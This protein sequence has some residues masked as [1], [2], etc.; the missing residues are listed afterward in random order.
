MHLNPMIDKLSQGKVAFGGSTSDLS[1]ENAHAIA[2]ADIDYIYVDMEHPPL[3]LE[4]LHTFLI[5]MIDKEAAVKK[6][7]PAPQVAPLARFPPYGREQA[8][9]IV[10]P[11]LDI[12]LMGVIFNGTET[13]EHTLN[14]VQNMRYPQRKGS[15][16]M[17]PLGLRGEANLA[18]WFWGVPSATYRQHSDLWLLNPQGDLIDVMLI[19]TVEGVKNIDDILSVRG[20]GGV[21][22]GPSDLSN[23]LGVAGGSPEVEAA[24]QTILKS[25]LSHNIPCG[26]TAGSPTAMQQRIKQGFRI[27]GAGGAGG[28]LSPSMDAALR[29]GREALK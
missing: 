15:P 25:C 4:G 1:L 18:T 11:A 16:Y 10:K 20:V 19:E 17:E 12:G 13:N 2:R 9:W 27:L 3:N 29:A 28:G 5:G 22:I 8:Q 26:I 24:I 14:D 23:S 7:S 21:Y 6:G